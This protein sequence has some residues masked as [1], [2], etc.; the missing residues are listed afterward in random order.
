M[1]T[2]DSKTLIGKLAAYPSNS[3]DVESLL[4]IIQSIM[5]ANATI[6]EPVPDDEW[7][8]FGKIRKLTIEAP[9]NKFEEFNK[10]GSRVV[11]RE[12]FRALEDSQPGDEVLVK[13]QPGLG[14]ISIQKNICSMLGTV[15]NPKFNHFTT[16]RTSGG[17]LVNFT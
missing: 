11:V 12:Y 17:I 16:S 5:P 13:I 14:P 10:D 3:I 6:E 8:G 1:T 15:K 2:I 7:L 4:D 9:S